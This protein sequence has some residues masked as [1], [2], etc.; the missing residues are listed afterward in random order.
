MRDIMVGKFDTEYQHHNRLG[1]HIFS[2]EDLHKIHAATLEVLEKTGIFVE[3]ANA[4]ELFSG[5]G[6]IIDNK[7]KVVRIP[8]G[9]VEESIRSAPSKIVLA[10]RDPKHDKI[11]DGN[12]VFF[13]NFS[14]G[15]Q[16]VDLYTGKHRTPIKSDLVNVARVVD[17]LSD[18]DI[19]EKALSAHD[20]PQEIA[21]L[22]NAEAFLSHTTKHCCFGP[23]NGMLLKKIVAMG[24]AIVGGTD[25]LGE[26]PIISFTTCPVSPLKLINECCEIIMAA[27]RSGLTVNILSMALA[28]G[29]SPVTL[30]GTIVTHN[31]EVL[32]G[33]VLNQLTS[34]GAPIIYGSSTT[35]MD[36]RL[37]AAAVGSPECAIIS[38]AV[39]RLARYYSLPSYVAGG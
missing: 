11:L 27:A 37:A 32:G 17:F 13:T 21:P 26:R 30:A 6:A 19:C 22:H 5:A 3:N 38:G 28:G 36:L 24:A 33:V 18:V 20:V 8:P 16:V 23:G 1:L 4:L 35:A 14:E 34:K 31:A 2:N 10:G 15:I 12:Q 9:L 7:K 29:T 39:A 25:R